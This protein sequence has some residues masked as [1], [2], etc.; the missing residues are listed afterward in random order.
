MGRPRKAWSWSG[1]RQARAS[2]RA[3]ASK[4]KA[5][6]SG[7]IGSR[8]GTSL[9]GPVPGPISVKARPALWDLQH[10]SYKMAHV[11]PRLW[12]E[13][14][15]LLDMD[16]KEAKADWVYMRDYYKKK[17]KSLKTSKRSGTA[18]SSPC[19]SLGTWVADEFRRLDPRQRNKAIAH[20]ADYFASLQ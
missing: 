8:R 9:S 17:C 13:V 7:P 16:S 1:R 19:S 14:S 6:G 5:A 12:R 10:P 11:K 15:E 2:A 18:P 3:Q 4:G 20:F